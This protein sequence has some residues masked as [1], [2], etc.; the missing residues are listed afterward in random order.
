M[1]IMVYSLLWVMISI[2]S[3]LRALNYGNDGLFLV[4]DNP[5]G[6][7]VCDGEYQPETS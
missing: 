6:P 5:E 1:V 3:T 7:S 4:V 2:C